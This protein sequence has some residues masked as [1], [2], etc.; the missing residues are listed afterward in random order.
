MSADHVASPR[1][2]TANTVLALV[3]LAL[4]GLAAWQ[5]MRVSALKAELRQ[6]QRALESRVE[7]LAIEKLKFRREE[8]AAVVQWLD[9]FYRG[10]EACSGRAGWCAPIAG[11][12]TAKPSAYGCSM[13][14]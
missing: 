1:L 8:M 9:D 14:I 6:S 10:K 13:S 11:D 12:R 2:K 5:A 7:S 4:L 3:V